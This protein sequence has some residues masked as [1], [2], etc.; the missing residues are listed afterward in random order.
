MFSIVVV[1]SNLSKVLLLSGC[2]PFKH[3]SV[4]L[5]HVNLLYPIFELSSSKVLKSSVSFLI[6]ILTYLMLT[7]ALYSYF[8]LTLLRYAKVCK[9]AKFST[10]D[11]SSVSQS[12]IPLTWL[13][14]M[15]SFQQCESNYLGMTRTRSL[16][17]I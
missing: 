14:T 13:I 17:C 10:P 9:K 16:F 11:E 15:V 6:A 12:L 3:G 5:I 4:I 8:M 1:Q 7:L 2:V